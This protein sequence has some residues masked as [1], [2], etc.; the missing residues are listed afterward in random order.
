[1]KRNDELL[2]KVAERFLFH[3]DKA[4]SDNLVVAEV[5]KG[6]CEIEICEM[7]MLTQR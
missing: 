1:M 3:R 6:M 5:A 4:K 7:W 2:L